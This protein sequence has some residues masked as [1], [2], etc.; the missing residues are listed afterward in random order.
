MMVSRSVEGGRADYCTQDAGRFS[1]D[2]CF[3]SSRGRL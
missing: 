3:K 1:D 2:K